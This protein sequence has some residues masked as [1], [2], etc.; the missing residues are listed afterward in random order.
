LN[1]ARLGSAH[2]GSP[3]RRFLI[4]PCAAFSSTHAPLSHQLMLTLSIFPAKTGTGHN[5]A[6][7]RVGRVSASAPRRG[8]NCGLSFREKPYGA[9]GF[10]G[11]TGFSAPGTSRSSASQRRKREIRFRRLVLGAAQAPNRRSAA[12]GLPPLDVPRRL[13]KRRAHFHYFATV[14]LVGD[15]VPSLVDLAQRRLHRAV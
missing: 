13:V 5:L 2:L 15:R 6:E 12:N 10:A 11:I 14:R 7:K 3:P 4:N 9:Y 1:R 8:G